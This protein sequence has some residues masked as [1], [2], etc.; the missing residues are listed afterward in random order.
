MKECSLCQLDAK[1][2][3]IL[4]LLEGRSVSLIPTNKKPDKKRLR[5]GIQHDFPHENLRRWGCYFFALMRWAEEIRNCGFEENEIIPLFNLAQRQ[6]MPN[7][8]GDGSRIPIVN[9]NSFI[10]DPVRVLNFLAERD[11]VSRVRLWTNDGS[12]PTPGEKIFVMREKQSAN[13]AHFVLII[14]GKRWDS[15]LPV[16]PPRNQAGFRVLV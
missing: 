13:L 7:P 15:L 9:S 4:E 3:R 8:N 12:H 14:K 6:T 2:D 5:Q 16:S 11:V 10:N 1:V